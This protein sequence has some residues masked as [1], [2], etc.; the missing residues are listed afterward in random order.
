MFDLPELRKAR[1]RLR[2]NYHRSFRRA[3]YA[4]MRRYVDNLVRRPPASHP[5]R[6]VSIGLTHRCQNRCEFCATGA[7]NRR[8]SDELSTAEAERLL[9]AVAGSRF[10]FDNISLMGGECLL[11]PDLERLIRHATGLGLFVHISTNGLALDERRV[12]SLLEAGLNSA[13]VAWS[14]AP[15][16][17]ARE[18]RQR[19]TVLR[20]IRACVRQDL[21]C[22]LSVCVRREDLRGGRLQQTLAL[23]RELGAAG[24]R[25][26][27]VRL[28]GKWLHQG[29][30]QVLDPRQER[31]LRRLCRPGYAFLTDDACREDGV[32]CP[33]LRRSLA[34]V[35]PDG[36]VHPCHFLPFSFGNVRQRPLDRVLE[37]MWQHPMLQLQG[38]TCPLQDSAFRARH[39]APLA[40]RTPL[41][42]AV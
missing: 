10:V 7:Y 11:R 40:P 18:A 26:M 36:E 29:S 2:F 16:S 9:T 39:I 5:R 21:P 12:A 24:V 31:Q 38:Y 4:Q 41:P 3:G 34:Y 27:P 14:A 42:V 22:F 13:F 17:D 15:P 32:R 25:L 1:N 37:R 28:S 20:G 6:F 8:A 35:S 19:Q 33:A 23:G 30:G